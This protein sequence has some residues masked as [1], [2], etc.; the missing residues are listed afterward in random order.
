MKLMDLFTR[1]TKRTMLFETILVPE[2]KK[3]LAD[4]KNYPPGAGVLIGGVAL[5]YYCRPRTT[6]DLDFLFAS[7]ADI[8]VATSKFKKIRAHAWIHKSTQVEVELLTPEFLKMSKTVVEQVI[9]TANDISGI[10]IA[11]PSGLVALKLCANRYKD[12]A[13]I[14]ELIKYQPSEIENNI[15]S[16]DLTTEQFEL[17]QSLVI[18]AHQELE[19]EIRD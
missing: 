7:E 18:D 15:G 3:A 19:S 12:R 1:K 9:A 4:L 16:Y 2:L 11:S 5:S 14:V 10:K 6:E 17:Y 8:P 13:D